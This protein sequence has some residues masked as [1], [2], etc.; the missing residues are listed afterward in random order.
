MSDIAIHAVPAHRL[1]EYE[2]AGRAAELLCQHYPGHP[3]AVFVDSEQ[4][5]GVMYIYNWG[6]SFSYGYVLH[7]STVYAD[8]SLRCVIRAGGEILERAHLPRGHRERDQV[9]R[10]IEGVPARH[11]PI[12]G[13]I[14]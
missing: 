10:H 5:G 6:V 12:D 2:L 4:S 14:I 3:W 11:Q 8:P 7:L 9:V 1:G 13:I